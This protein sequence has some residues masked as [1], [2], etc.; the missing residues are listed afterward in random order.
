M[1]SVEPKD[2][3]QGAQIID[4]REDFEYAT[5]HAVGV[6][7]IPMGELVDRVNEIDPDKDIYVI[8]HSGQRS[9]QVA[10]YLERSLGWDVFNISGGTQRWVAQGLP[11]E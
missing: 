11:V 4:V 2:V 9:Q 10:Q 6:T 5:Q 3:P 7:H 1:M 8:C